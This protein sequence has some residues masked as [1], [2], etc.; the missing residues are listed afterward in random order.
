MYESVAVEK[1]LESS[2]TG[3]SLSVSLSRLQGHPDEYFA[4]RVRGTSMTE[5]D[6]P[7]DAIVVMRKEQNLI[8]GKT[9]LFRHEGG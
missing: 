3:E 1:P 6:I 8:D 5:A 7:D 2:D 9:Y 4:V